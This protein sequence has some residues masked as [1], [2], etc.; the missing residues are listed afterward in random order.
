V[1]ALITASDD[2]I[3]LSAR[4]STCGGASSPSALAALRHPEG[5][6]EDCLLDAAGLLVF[7]YYKENLKDESSSLL[8]KDHSY[9]SSSDLSSLC[10]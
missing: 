2:P 7:N 10:K 3:T 1:T 4:A 6:D 8:H 5:D 9:A